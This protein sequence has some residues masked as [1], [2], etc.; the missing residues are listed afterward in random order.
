MNRT[1]RSLARCVPLIAVTLALACTGEEPAA[2]ASPQRAVAVEA[3]PAATRDVEIR[4]RAVGT[5]RA[6]AEAEIRPQV[7][8]LIAEIRYGEGAH[9]A[10]GELLVRLDDRKAVARQ[11]LAKAAA[12]SARAKLKVARQRLERGKRLIADQ[13][14]SEETFESTE[15]EYLAAAADLREQE[16]AVEL[17]ARELDDYYIRAPFDGT[18]GARLV[19]VG[20]YVEKG[21]PLVVLLQTDPIE[22]EFRLPDREAGSLAPGHPVTITPSSGRAPIVGELSFINPQVDASTRMLSLRA[23]ADNADD[24]LRHGQ[25]VELSVLVDVHRDQVVILEQA[26]LSTGGKTWVYVVNAGRAERREVTL[27]QRM[28]PMVEA[29]AGIERDD[30][31]IVGGQHRVSEGDDVEILDAQAKSGA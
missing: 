27:G 6:S 28:P 4:L 31:L 20:N 11:E 21:T 1:S 25:F 14:I 22:I 10:D 9:V 17:A 8:G 3:A 24:R 19:D 13:L 2:G 23:R 30:V 12:D 16:A 7:D 26:V 15:A 18:V 5:V 29:L